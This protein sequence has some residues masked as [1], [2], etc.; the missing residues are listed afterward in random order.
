LLLKNII[1][2]FGRFETSASGEAL[3][4]LMEGGQ[5]RLQCKATTIDFKTFQRV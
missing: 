3:L 2:P 5:C 1:T 4:L